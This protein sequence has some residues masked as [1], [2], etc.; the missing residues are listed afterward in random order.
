MSTG[1]WGSSRTLPSPHASGPFRFTSSEWAALFPAGPA[2]PQTLSLASASPPARPRPE[3]LTRA[4]MLAALEPA[5]VLRAVAAAQLALGPWSARLLMPVNLGSAVSMLSMLAPL[6]VFGAGT[7]GTK[8]LAALSATCVW[9]CIGMPMLLIIRGTSVKS[10]AAPEPDDAL[11]VASL[12]RSGTGEPALDDHVLAGVARY[13]H[14][15]RM[16]SDYRKSHEEHKDD[17]EHGHGT[18]FSRRNEGTSLLLAHEPD[19]ELCPCP[20]PSCAGSRVASAGIICIVE[21]TVRAIWMLLMLSL[22]LNWTAFWTFASQNWYTWWSCILSI[23]N[24]AVQ[25]LLAVLKEYGTVWSNARILGLHERLHR[26]AVYLALST[27]LQ[28]HRDALQYPDMDQPEP[29]GPEPYQELHANLAS[30]WRG[31]IPYIADN[32][33]F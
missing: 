27:F 25:L 30:I 3:P 29:A 33:Y 14:L 26:R 22:I 16:D 11:S 8:D 4:A 23:A 24:V 13:Y 5:P 12:P 28:R 2:P 6:W 9:S 20:L 15:A 31:R 17:P 7:F 32:M 18:G 10:R 1:T 21:A 19:D